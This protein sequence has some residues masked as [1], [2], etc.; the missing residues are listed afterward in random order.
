[1]TDTEKIMVPMKW[2]RRDAVGSCNMCQRRDDPWVLE[3]DLQ[4][5]TFRLCLDCSKRLKESLRV[6]VK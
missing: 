6:K 2:E 4:S 5:M 1:M 3:V